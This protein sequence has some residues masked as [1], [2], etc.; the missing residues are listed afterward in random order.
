[1]KA[2]RNARRS[3]AIR[4]AC[5]FSRIT[6]NAGMAIAARNPM[7]VTATMISRRVKPATR[8]AREG[9][10]QRSF[11]SIAMTRVDRIPQTAFTAS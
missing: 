5:D 4:A 9:T 10:E 2:V 1:V 8:R 3:P 6:R 11:P 7:T